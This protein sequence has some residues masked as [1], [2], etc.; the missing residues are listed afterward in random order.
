M[1][2]GKEGKERVKDMRQLSD[3]E[4]GRIVTI[5]KEGKPLPEDY[6]ATLFDTKKEYE[7]TYSIKDREEDILAD[8][9]TVPLQ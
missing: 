3:G 1:G 6:K 5:L 7:L 8:T 4:I 2:E 9:M